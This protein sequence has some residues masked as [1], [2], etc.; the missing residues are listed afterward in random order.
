[1]A[2]KQSPKKEVVAVTRKEIR[3]IEPLIGEAVR[4]EDFEAY[5]EILTSRLGV[6]RGSEQCH[7]FEAKFWTALAELR[8]NKMQ[9]P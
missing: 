5:M 7:F 4:R 3:E 8:K 6:E 9:R 1:M 2:N